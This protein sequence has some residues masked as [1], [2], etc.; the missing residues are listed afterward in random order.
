[1]KIRT[2]L[3]INLP[4]TIR[5]ELTRILE[6]L[7]KSGEPVRWVKAE[8]LHITLQF[9]GEVEEHRLEEIDQTLE[10]EDFPVFPFSIRIRGTGVFPNLRSPRV[11]WLGLDYPDHLI[12]LQQ[13]VTDV[14][15]RLGFS[16]EDREFAPHLTLGR[17]KGRVQPSFVEKFIQMDYAAPEFEVTSFEL[18]KSELLPQGA[19]YTVLRTYPAEKN[20]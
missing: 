17:A 15:S 4:G 11:F 6:E 20:I 8:S 12:Q 19:R 7:Q 2:F 1:M 18:M 10:R 5:T 13:K 16:P 9:L 3:A 14:L